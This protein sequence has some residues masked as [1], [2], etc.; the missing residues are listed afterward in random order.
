MEQI[1]NIAKILEDCP[2]G[3]ELY[4]PICGKCNFSFIQFADSIIKVSNKTGVYSFAKDGTYT[5]A[6]DAECLLFPSKDNRDWST[7]Q[8]L[9]MDGDVV[10][11]TNGIWIGITTG[12]E[13]GKFIPTYCIIQCDDKFEA[14]LDRKGEWAFNRL[15]TEEEKQKLFNAIKENGYKWNEET[16]TLEKVIE[17]KFKVGDK[18]IHSDRG[19]KK[20]TI[21]GV[22]KTLYGVEEVDYGIPI[23][24][25]DEYELVPNKFD[26]TTLQPFDKVLVRDNNEQ[27]WTC[28]WFSF[29]DT[30]QVYPFACVGHYVSQCIPYEGNQHLLGTTD[31]CDEHFKTWE[32]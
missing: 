12:G 25:Q 13:K 21:N 31:D 22:Y 4:S 14:Y 28:D 32:I 9:F 15:A 16:K 7:F 2:K 5:K 11:T 6:I 17:P 8:K 26:V 30:K 18:V 24:N 20:L 29:H 27:F 10:A 23:E 3:T 1:L 19:G